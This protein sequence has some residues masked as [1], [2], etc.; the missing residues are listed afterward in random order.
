MHLL[1]QQLVSLIK[2]IGVLLFIFLFNQ[3]SDRTSRS[4]SQDTTK[5]DCP[6]GQREAIADYSVKSP[7]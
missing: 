3:W 7:V 5:S 6:K 1:L 4:F 2:D